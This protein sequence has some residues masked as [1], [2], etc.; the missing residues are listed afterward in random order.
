MHTKFKEYYALL[1]IVDD[2]TNTVYFIDRSCAIFKSLDDKEGHVGDSIESISIQ[3]ANKT[4]SQDSLI[5][6]LL[7]GGGSGRIDIRV[8]R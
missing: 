2:Y 7:S 6:N 4:I 3:M 8:Q 1:D 5:D